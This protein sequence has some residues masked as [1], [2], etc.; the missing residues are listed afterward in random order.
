LLTAILFFFICAFT[1]DFSNNNTVAFSNNNLPL[2]HLKKKYVQ[3]TK[4]DAI[5]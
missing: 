5:K 2:P 4:N 3:P 1:S